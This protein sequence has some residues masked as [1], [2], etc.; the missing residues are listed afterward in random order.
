MDYAK[1]Y[2][3]LDYVLEQMKK[4]VGDNLK[5]DI[6][7]EEKVSVNEKEKK[8]IKKIIIMKNVWKKLKSLLKKIKS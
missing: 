4:K 5:E 3:L 6:K 1:V 2:G 7:K 8:K